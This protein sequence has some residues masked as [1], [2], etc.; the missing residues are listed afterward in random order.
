VIHHLAPEGRGY[1]LLPSGSLFRGGLEARFRSELLRS[2]AVEAIIAL[3]RA[4]TSTPTAAAFALWV[5]RPPVSNPSPVLMIDGTGERTLDRQLRQRLADTLQIWRQRPEEFEPTAG[6]ATTVPVLE[7]LAGDA[8]LVPSRWL[9]EPELIDPAAINESVERAVAELAAAYTELPNQPPHFELEPVAVPVG[10]VRV[11][12]LAELG[13]ATLL[14]AARFKS[15]NYSEEGLPV[16]LPGDIHDPWRRHEPPKFVDP[17]LVDHRSVTEPGDV[18]FTTIGGLRTRVD[19]DG[20]HVLGTSL[21]ALRLRPNTFD[22]HAF[23]ALLTS[24]SNRR[25]LTGTTIPR[26]NVLEL[27]IPQ[28]DLLSAARVGEVLRELDHELEVTHAAAAGA[29]TLRRALIDALASGAATIGKN[30]E[31]Q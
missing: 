28:F 24:E 18:V 14:R 27:E 5:V 3:P 20:G 31:G 4:A 16:W 29:E 13:L 30:S 9:Y 22:P 6:F 23:A 8:T 10:R 15:D 26:V 12:D 21:Q 2:G 7:L 19:T 25:L 11:R 1:V 17:A